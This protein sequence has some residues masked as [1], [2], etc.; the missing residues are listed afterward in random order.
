MIVIKR[1][2]QTNLKGLY[3]MK[4][5]FK[6]ILTFT[7]LIAPTLII[8]QP[9]NGPGMR[10]DWEEMFKERQ[11]KILD[12]MVKELTLTKDQEAKIKAIQEENSKEMK[13]RMESMR[14]ARDAAGMNREELE[15]RR[16]ENDAKIDAVL[17]ADQK[18][19]WDKIR[20]ENWENARDRQENN[21]KSWKKDDKKDNKKSD[22][23]PEKKS[24]N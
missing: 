3:T 5:L 20:E 21:R 7:L 4:T 12:R 10:G 14:E 16:K 24:E 1:A 23:K 17:S 19:K 18:K 15:K 13:K 8:A 9:G 2:N 11:Q 6:L 22:K